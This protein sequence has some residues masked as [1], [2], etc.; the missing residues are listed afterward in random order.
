VVDTVRRVIGLEVV[1]VSDV[2][3]EETVFPDGDA[4]G[5]ALLEAEKNA[6]GLGLFGGLDVMD[7]VDDESAFR[8]FLEKSAFV[9]FLAGPLVLERGLVDV[10]SGRIQGIG[11]RGVA[12]AD[13]GS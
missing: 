3:A 7:A 2:P 10:R 8:V 5:L 1:D 9:G 6:D 12:L 11:E 13:G 4:V